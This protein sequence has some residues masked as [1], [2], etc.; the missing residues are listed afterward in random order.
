MLRTGDGP[1]FQSY[2]YEVMCDLV[3]K[4]PAKI[5]AGR[6]PTGGVLPNKDE[7]VLHLRLGDVI[8]R[9]P[10]DIWEAGHSLYSTFQNERSDSK[11]TLK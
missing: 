7:A 8:D 1:G 4:F 10:G 3:K 6:Y 2:N 9:Q 5:D 11:Y